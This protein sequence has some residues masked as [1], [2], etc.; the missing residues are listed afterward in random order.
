MWEKNKNRQSTETAYLDHA[1]QVTQPAGGSRGS[2]MLTLVCLAA[3]ETMCI[4][5]HQQ[6]S[7]LRTHFQSHQVTELPKTSETCDAH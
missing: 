3:V 2:E 7:K 4:Y 1:L 5:T 6:L